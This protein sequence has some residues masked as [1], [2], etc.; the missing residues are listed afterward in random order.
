MLPRHTWILSAEDDFQMFKRLAVRRLPPTLVKLMV[1]AMIGCGQRPPDQVPSTPVQETP[2]APAV[3]IVSQTPER[4]DPRTRW[5]Y[6]KGW[7]AKGVG[8]SWYEHNDEA[9]RIRGKAW[10]FRQTNFSSECIELYDASRGV[11]VR[12]GESSAE[13][14]W[15]MD[16]KEAAWKPLLAGRWDAPK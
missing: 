4:T 8:D 12:L 3:P 11:S 1:V 13:A 14:R 5:V 7:F 15:D 16:G 6:E 9:M 10:E 2:S